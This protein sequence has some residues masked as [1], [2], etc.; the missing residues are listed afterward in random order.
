MHAQTRRRTHTIGPRATAHDRTQ[1]V[2][3]DGILLQER[4]QRSAKL[5]P[6]V[7]GQRQ[8]AVVKVVHQPTPRRR[9][10]DGTRL[11]RSQLEAYVGRY[12]LKQAHHALD[13]VGGCAHD[14][15]VDE[16]PRHQVVWLDPELGVGAKLEDVVHDGRHSDGA[17]NAG[18]EP[19]RKAILLNPCARV[20]TEGDAHAPELPDGFRG[21]AMLLVPRGPIPYNETQVRGVVRLLDRRH[22]L[23]RC[24]KPQRRWPAHI[25]DD[26][27]LIQCRHAAPRLH[28]VNLAPGEPPLVTVPHGQ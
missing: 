8:D 15:V 27:V 1:L 3:R 23:V 16:A 18:R 14:G 26:A 20:G 22:H 24:R 12:F 7:L 6:S 21:Q 28:R 17:R 25:R 19:E 2:L 9:G 4:V 10:G 13:H 11:V 5:V